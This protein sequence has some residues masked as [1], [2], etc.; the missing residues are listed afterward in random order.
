LHIN[1]AMKFNPIT[2]DLY[3]DKGEFIKT[4]NCPYKMNW[5]NLE[6]ANLTS[7]KCSVC[8]H[9]VTDT[10]NF[11]DEEILKIVKQ[12]PNSCLKIDLNQNNIKII[13]NGILEQK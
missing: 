11:E 13:S 10:Q 6:E 9:L 1:K 2:K 8:E 7:R 4:M 5:G 3:T 12:N